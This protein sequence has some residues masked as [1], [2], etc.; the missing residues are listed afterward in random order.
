M[1]HR[2]ASFTN[3]DWDDPTGQSQAQ[4]VRWLWDQRYLKCDL[5]ERAAR[6]YAFYEGKQLHEWSNFHRQMKLPTHLRNLHDP[7]LQ[8]YLVANV[9]KPLLIQKHSKFSRNEPIWNVPAFTV[10]MSGVGVMSSSAMRCSWVNPLQPSS[11]RRMSI[12]LPTW[13]IMPGQ[14]SFTPAMTSL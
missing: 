12:P 2:A 10:S 14:R 4:A 7:N 1:N 8:D 13:V 3:T 9:I 11:S 6:N 5:E